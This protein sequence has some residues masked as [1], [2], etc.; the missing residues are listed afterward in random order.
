MFGSEAYT[1]TPYAPATRALEVEKLIATAVDC[2]YEK[3]TDLFDRIT[4]MVYGGYE[5][6][7]KMFSGAMQSLEQSQNNK[8]FT[9]PEMPD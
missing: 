1:Y 4:K 7:L 5:D 8:R 9:N 2:G 6:V 3:N